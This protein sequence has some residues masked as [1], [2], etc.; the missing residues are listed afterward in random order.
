MKYHCIFLKMQS[1]FEL[2]T[3]F[4]KNAEFMQTLHSLEFKSEY[5]EFNLNM[6]SSF[7]EST[8]NPY[9][10]FQKCRV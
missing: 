7:A 10:G 4:F 2:P 5:A 9:C 3:L 8:G 6:Q 1:S